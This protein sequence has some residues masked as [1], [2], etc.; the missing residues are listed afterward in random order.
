MQRT[1]GHAMRHRAITGCILGVVFLLLTGLG[2]PADAALGCFREPG[3]SAAT[4]T[5]TADC[6]GVGGVDCTAGF[7]AC[8]GSPTDP[9]C[10]CA[11]IHAPVLSPRGSL[12]AVALVALIGFLSLWRTART[13]HEQV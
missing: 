6:V 8:P 7:C 1:E 3:F 13:R 4:C 2:S 9:F 11:A 12:G 5:E 10:R